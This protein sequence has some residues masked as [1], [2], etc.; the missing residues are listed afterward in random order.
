MG[1][2]LT[3]TSGNDGPS[4][5][6]VLTNPL[7]FDTW[8]LRRMIPTAYVNPAVHYDQRPIQ[9]VRCSQV[10]KQ[11]AM[12]IDTDEGYVCRAEKACAERAKDIY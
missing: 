2:K 4:S 8:K 10:P 5:R 3:S 6:R 12:L 1:K 9:C 7:A 11:R